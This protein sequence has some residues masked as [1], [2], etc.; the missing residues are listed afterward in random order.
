MYFS[1]SNISVCS[2]SRAVECF[3]VYS[4]CTEERFD[5]HIHSPKNHTRLC[6][7]KYVSWI[8]F[9]ASST[10]FSALEYERFFYLIQPNECL[11]LKVPWIFQ[12]SYT[13][14]LVYFTSI[15]F[16]C[17]RYVNRKFILDIE[18]KFPCNL[19]YVI[20]L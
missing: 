3:I 19:N 4:S 6:I 7:K 20:Y 12:Y 8:I 11:R 14:L 18:V 9:S 2:Q 17:M 5:H 10:S 15:S 13:K 1:S 16:L